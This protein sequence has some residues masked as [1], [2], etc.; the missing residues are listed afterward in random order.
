M[1]ENFA[2]EW[3]EKHYIFFLFLGVVISIL[4]LIAMAVFALYASLEDDLKK[5]NKKRISSNS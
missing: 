4:T 2:K 1:F 5:K 3:M